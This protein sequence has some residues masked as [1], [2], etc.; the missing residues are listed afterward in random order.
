M[1]PTT[2][3]KLRLSPRFGTG[4]FVEAADVPLMLAIEMLGVGVLPPDPPLLPARAGATVSVRPP[5]INANV[6]AIWLFMRRLL[7]AAARGEP[8]TGQERDRPR[9]PK[10]LIPR[11]GEL[12]ASRTT[13][14]R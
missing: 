11:T 4:F 7:S 6:S 10:A 1:E 13:P 14:N 9:R 3:A 2:V 12:F 5:T 8:P